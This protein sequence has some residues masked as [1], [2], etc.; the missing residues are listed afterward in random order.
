MVHRAALPLQMLQSCKDRKFQS[1][2]VLQWLSIEFEQLSVTAVASF[3]VDN[4]QSFFRI[5]N[6]QIYVSAY[7]A[8][9][10]CYK[11][12]LKL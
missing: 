2:E 7:Q 9:L 8:L 12:K 3:D 4:I 10:P 11:L 1:C 6:R 5:F